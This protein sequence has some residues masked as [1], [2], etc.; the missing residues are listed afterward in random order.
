M[1]NFFRDLRFSLRSLARRP[2]FAA[3][4]IATLAVGIGANSAIFSVVNAVLL[5]PLPYD[6]PDDVVVVWETSSGAKADEHGGVSG[7]NFSDWQRESKVF[8]QL[9]AFDDKSMILTGQNGPEQIT[10]TTASGSFFEV[11]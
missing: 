5:R 10:G 2:A 11:L 9:A 3:A 4:A 7:P 6:K 1:F 8:T